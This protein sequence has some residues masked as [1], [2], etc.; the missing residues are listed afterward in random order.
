M[1]NLIKVFL[2]GLISIFSMKAIAWHKESIKPENSFKALR[3]NFQDTIFI[4]NYVCTKTAYL[5]SK[6]N[7]A[8]KTKIKIPKNVM[9]TTINRSGD[10]EY[11][12][13]SVSSN[14]SFRGWFLK[15]DLQSMFLSPPKTHK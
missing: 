8:S 1:K 3:Y 7:L 13:F 15:S 10:F 5:Y 11:G 12:D 9:I 14:K 2:I 6:P 4:K